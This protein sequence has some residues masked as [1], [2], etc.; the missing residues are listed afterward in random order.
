MRK[1]LLHQPGGM[2]SAQTS[3]FTPMPIDRT[4]VSNNTPCQLILVVAGGMRLRAHQR[5]FRSPFGNLRR[6]HSHTFGISRQKRP[7]PPTAPSPEGKVWYACPSLPS[8]LGKV[9]PQR[10]IRSDKHAGTARKRAQ[11]NRE[12]GVERVEDPS[13]VQGSALLGSRGNAPCVS[14]INTRALHEEVANSIARKGQGRNSL[15]ESRGRA[16]G[17]V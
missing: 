14:L 3:R 7:H 11:F 13:Q 12:K 15:A 1:Q 8:P 16:S 4:N 5:A 6:A 2:R 10:R 17:G 9:S